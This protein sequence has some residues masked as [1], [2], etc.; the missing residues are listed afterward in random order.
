MT[1]PLRVLTAKATFSEFPLDDLDLRCEPGGL[2]LGFGK[3]ELVDAA[4]GRW[5]ILKVIFGGWKEEGAPASA[6]YGLVTG[7][8]RFKELERLDV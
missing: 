7:G 1:P 5:L 2:N 3:I 6:K 4:M 8:G